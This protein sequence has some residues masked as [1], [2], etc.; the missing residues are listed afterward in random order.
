[1]TRVVFVVT[2]GTYS[3]YHIIGVYTDALLA[4]TAV[5]KE[6]DARIEVYPLNADKNIQAGAWVATMALRKSNHKFKPFDVISTAWCDGLFYDTPARRKTG[7]RSVVEGYGKTEE[8]AIRS[9]S[10]KVRELLMDAKP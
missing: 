8:H 9:A 2:A 3:D 1:M 7:S 4:T 10:Q 5:A 6:Y